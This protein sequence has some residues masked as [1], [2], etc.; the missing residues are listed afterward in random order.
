MVLELICNVYLFYSLFHFIG[1]IDASLM[2][3]M[4]YIVDSRY[5]A[6]YGS[7]YAIAQVAVCLAYSIGK[8]IYDIFVSTYLIAFS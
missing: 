4:A 5:V 2:P 7:V 8:C 1:I 6:L 3:M